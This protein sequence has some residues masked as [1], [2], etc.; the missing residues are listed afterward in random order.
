M[1]LD[2]AKRQ[3]DN[4]IEQIKNGK[5]YNGLSNK[6]N[7]NE[8]PVL[9]SDNTVSFWG[10]E[11]SSVSSVLLKSVAEML[12]A[13]S[14]PM[15]GA[16][17]IYPFYNA[18]YKLPENYPFAAENVMA[19]FGDYQ[20]GGHRYFK[21]Q[22]I[23]GPEDCSSSVGKATYL[24]TKQVQGINTG[25]MR[26]NPSQY[27]YELVTTLNSDVGE[28]LKLIQPGDIY[29]YKSHTA[30][31]ATEPDN[32]SNITTVQFNRDID[33]EENK[34]LGGGMYD[35][36]LINKA[37]EDPNSPVYIL[38]AKDLEPLH[39]EVSLL[40]FLSKIDT[41]YVELYQDGPTEDIVGNCR[42]FFESCEQA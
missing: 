13:E 29:L 8:L 20:Y 31:I 32:H 35:Y 41:K 15:I 39:E 38:R 34:M 23:F 14:N 2:Y 11:N 36:S 10:N 26:E 19:L 18:N 37:A 17:T 1:A 4:I 5:F 22:L 6:I 27:G 25:G 40:G 24:T 21:D 33:R 28:E 9:Q 16:A 3:D 12:E 42:I 30:I 7:S